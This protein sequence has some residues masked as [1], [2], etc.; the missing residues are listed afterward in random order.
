MYVWKPTFA[1]I[2]NLMKKHYTLGIA[3]VLFACTNV[4]SSSSAS[5]EFA[6]S[7]PMVTITDAVGFDD[8]T[9]MLGQ[10]FLPF[11]GISL[12]TS[13]GEDLSRYLQV[14]GHVDMSRV[15]TYTLDYFLEHPSLTWSTTRQVMVESGNLI[16]SVRTKVYTTHPFEALGQGTYRTGLA[17]DITHPTGPAFMEPHLLDRPVPTNGWWT[18]LAMSN[19]GGSNGIYNNPLR[20]SFS[21]DGVE[22]T[23][24][25]QGFTQYWLP[26]GNQTIAQFSLA[27]KDFNLKPT[28]LAT[29]YQTKV[30]D[31]S[32]NLVKVAMRNNDSLRDDMVITYNQGSPYIFAEAGTRQAIT[33]SAGIDGV[34]DYDYFTLDGTPIAEDTLTTD[35]IIVK[36]LD[37]HVGYQTNPPASVGQPIYANRYFVVNLPKNTSVTISN[38]GHPFGLK[39][40]MTLLLGD[41]NLI[42]I[43]AINNLEEA[44]FYHEHGY[45]LPQK[46]HGTYDVNHDEGL[47]RSD[48]WV[49]T[50][51]TR[52]DVEELP[53]LAMLPHQHKLFPANTPYTTMTVRGQLKMLIGR[54]FS[55][56]LPFYGVVPSLPLPTDSGFSSETMIEHLGRIDDQTNLLDPENFINDETPYWNS[57]ATYAL[58]Q[59]L[60]QAKQLNAH[61]IVTSFSDKLYEHLTDWFTISNLDDKRYLYYNDV[62]GTTYYSDDGFGTASG[63]ADHAFTHGYLIFASA[64]LATV[65]PTFYRDYH[66]MV[67]LLL[68]DYL[69]DDATDTRFPVL[70]SFDRYA[71]HSWAHGFGTFAE[72]NNLESTGEVINSWVAGYMIAQLSGDQDLMDAA[73]YGF[74]NETYATQQYWFD[75]D[76]DI[77][78]S[79]YREYAG[80]AGMIWGGKYDYATWFGA[81]PTFIYGIQWIPTGEYLSH[82]I[83]GEAKLNRFKQIFAKYLA[84]K[85]GSVDRWFSYMGSMH[86]ISDPA[87]ALARYSD[88]AILND[89]YPAEIGVAYWTMYARQTLTYKLDKALH[90]LHTTI[91]SSAYKNANGQGTIILYN[92][93]STAQ[94]ITFTLNGT[95]Q[96]VSVPPTST[97]QY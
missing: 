78:T 13:T 60:L 4:A 12:L 20:S 90:P 15:G 46:A 68:K 50:S 61:D 92:P 34:S 48:L 65:H 70:R 6:S 83:V 96:T 73:I 43:A 18:A 51:I 9:S 56:V 74:V 3:L 93:S 87:T 75:Y 23:Q 45:V 29:G 79:S 72:G 42:S 17:T 94:S 16:P 44:P 32:D 1:P 58:A 27:L 52:D 5:S 81:N 36:F 53:V 31:Y 69:N 2:L 57:K 82:L 8:T 25:G 30:I 14:N 97:V 39:H 26:E 54:G 49:Q 7:Q 66:G 71:G 62:W 41:S 37:R 33:L 28:S 85:G 67:D 55:Y 91:A 77:W 80:V 19:Y 10:A 63:I 59:G 47:V 35:A 84:A 89:E 24:S 11:N 64:V 38:T 40:K 88:S 95:S 76:R 86:A 22:I 21:N